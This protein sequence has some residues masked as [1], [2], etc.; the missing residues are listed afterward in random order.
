METALGSN[1]YPGMIYT[2]L[3]KA[4][5]SVEDGDNI[6]LGDNAPIL[7]CTGYKHVNK[8]INGQIIPQLVI[9]GINLNF[10]KPVE[11]LAVLE[12]IVN[13]YRSFYESDVY[14]AMLNNSI[15]LNTDLITNLI[16]NSK[17][18]LK[19]IQQNTGINLLNCFR[20][21]IISNVNNIRLIEY[22]L[23]QYIPF[24]SIVRSIKNLSLEQQAKLIS[25]MNQ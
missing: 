12:F 1:I 17:E 5:K 11:K 4:K 2:F 7:F 13:S 15:A 9:Q 23:W 21:Y 22:N 25:Y 18:F 8:I 6:N 20:S 19:L 16:F 24:C 14:N 3:Y 10:L